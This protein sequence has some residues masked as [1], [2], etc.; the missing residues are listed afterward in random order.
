[1]NEMGVANF[2]KKGWND[3]GDQVVN[4]IGC[5][6]CND[7]KT[8]DLRIVRPALIEAFQ[9]QGKD[10]KEVTHHL[11]VTVQVSTHLLKL[12]G[13]LVLQLRKLKLRGLSWTEYL[14]VLM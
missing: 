1:M 14:E 4:A 6:D 7:P 9:R 3:L 11:R 10:I 5:Q 2:Y 13:L 12:Q 8:M